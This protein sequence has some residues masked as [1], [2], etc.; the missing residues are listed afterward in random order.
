MKLPGNSSS[1]PEATLNQ[2]MYVGS[3]SQTVAK[4]I[5]SKDRL[6]MSATSRL[7]E[8]GFTSG[9]GTTEMLENQ[10]VHNHKAL[11]YSYLY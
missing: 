10:N 2:T 3:N 8:L 9:R 4:K 6:N 5:S 1:P 7:K 11:N